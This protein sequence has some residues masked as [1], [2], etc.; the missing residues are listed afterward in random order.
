MA[1]AGCSGSGATVGNGGNGGNGPGGSTPTPAG[2]VWHP[3]ANGDRFT[4]AGTLVITYDRSNQYPSPEPT[5]TT[6]MNVAQS[7][8]VTNPASFNGQNGV[9]FKVSETDNQTKPAAQTFS[10][11]GRQLLRV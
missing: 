7:V 1:V 10:E 3:A 9:D 8:A 2:V 6:V 5:S 11:N 4:L